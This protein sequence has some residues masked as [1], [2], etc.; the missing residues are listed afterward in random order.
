MPEGETAARLQILP[1]KSW[2]QRI[3]ERLRRL[4]HQSSPLGQQAPA[5]GGVKLSG[6]H[7]LNYVTT[8]SVTDAQHR[9]S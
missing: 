2:Q 5:P 1:L 9:P 3:S 6:H 8:I 7:A 4:E